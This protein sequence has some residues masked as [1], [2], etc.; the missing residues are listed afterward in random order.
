MSEL[1]VC[2]TLFR[3]YMDFEIVFNDKIAIQFS[4]LPMKTAVCVNAPVYSDI[5]IK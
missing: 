5:L 3:L 4:A 2:I 1:F